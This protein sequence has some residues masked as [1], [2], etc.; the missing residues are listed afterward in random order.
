[1]RNYKCLIVL[2]HTTLVVLQLLWKTYI[3]YFQNILLLKRNQIIMTLYSWG[4]LRMS[5]VFRLWSEE[6]VLGPEPRSLVFSLWSEVV[7]SGPEPSSVVFSLW[8]EVVVLKHCRKLNK[9]S[10]LDPTKN[11]GWAQVLG[12]GKQ[13]LFLIINVGEYRKSN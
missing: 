1:M 2:K 3:I 7:V 4:D 13:F 9:I 5:V 8:S 6:V 11:Q 12:K 10:N